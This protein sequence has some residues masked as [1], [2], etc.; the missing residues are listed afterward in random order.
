VVTESQQFFNS[1][2]Y[3]ISGTG[4]YPS[5][6]DGLKSITNN[7]L[8]M[9][10]FKPPTLR[11]I[12]LTAPYMHDGRSR[13]SMAPSST[14]ERAVV[15]SRSALMRGTAAPARERAS[16]RTSS[17]PTEANAPISWSSCRA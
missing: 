14:I 8:G 12:A 4:A 5:D 15:I 6:N 16:Y 10:K 9:G 13:T 7:P 1:G 17:S 11:N 2:R 3:N